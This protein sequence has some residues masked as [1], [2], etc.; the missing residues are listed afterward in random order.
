MESEQGFSEDPEKYEDKPERL[1]QSAAEML[2]QLQS[3]RNRLKGKVP[4]IGRY[5]A[6]LSLALAANVMAKAIPPSVNWLATFIESLTSLAMVVVAILAVRMRRD[7]GLR[8]RQRTGTMICIVVL[9]AAY[10]IV[11]WLPRVPQLWWLII[12]PIMGIVYGI[13]CWITQRQYVQDLPR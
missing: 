2:G 11:A 5:Y 10:L 7:S 3:D 13:L 4:N 9:I 8:Q 12:G 1:A 6:I